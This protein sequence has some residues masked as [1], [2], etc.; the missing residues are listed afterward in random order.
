MEQDATPLNSLKNEMA[1][2]QNKIALTSLVSAQRAA[3]V[4]PGLEPNFRWA[5]ILCLA[6]PKCPCQELPPWSFRLA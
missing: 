5:I 2:V 3:R 1:K 4:Q 6:S